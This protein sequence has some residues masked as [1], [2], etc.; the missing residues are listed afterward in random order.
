MF[1]SAVAAGMTVTFGAPMGAVMFSIEVSSTY[2]MAS[3]L[4]KG[5]FCATFAI[6]MF[7]LEEKLGWL[8]LY[9]RTSFDAVAIDHELF[10]FI[11]VGVLCGLLGSLFIHILGKIIFLRQRMNVPFISERY[12]WSI[13]VALIVGLITF[14]IHIFMLPD[15]TVI[16]TMFS[17]TEIIQSES[18]N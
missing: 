8:D 6:I 13:M 16:N 9:Q 12:Q 18:K 14:P 2:Y 11:I 3:N 1:A 5:F 4:F 15:Q 17:K 10:F 7:N